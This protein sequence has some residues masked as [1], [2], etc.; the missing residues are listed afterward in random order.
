MKLKP[1]AKINTLGVRVKKGMYSF[2]NG[3]VAFGNVLEHSQKL[4]AQRKAARQYSKRKWDE[5]KQQAP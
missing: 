3:C 5:D 2:D 4:E 1:K